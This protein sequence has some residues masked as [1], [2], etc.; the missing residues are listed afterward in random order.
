[1]KEKSYFK[2]LN[3]TVSIEIRNNRA[4]FGDVVA[5]ELDPR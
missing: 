2:L 4:M 1:M 5:V 3:R